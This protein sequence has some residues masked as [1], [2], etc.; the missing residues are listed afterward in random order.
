VKDMKKIYMQPATM[1]S[2]IESMFIMQS[3][4]GAAIGGNPIGI[5]E[6]GDAI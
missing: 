4:S 3:V 2:R 5:G 1:V 6:P